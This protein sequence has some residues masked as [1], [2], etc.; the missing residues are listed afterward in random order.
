M[1]TPFHLGLSLGLIK[2]SRPGIF[3]QQ[4]SLLNF[5]KSI[6]AGAEATFEVF[7]QYTRKPDVDFP[8]A[9]DIVTISVQVAID[10]VDVF[11]T[12]KSITV[13]IGEDGDFQAGSPRTRNL[14]VTTTEGR[15]M[16]TALE[17]GIENYNDK[18]KS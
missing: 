2:C 8:F 4:Q 17:R 18:K 6:S 3:T 7:P 9:D 14:K 13:A 10:Y 11:G 5:N 1:S 15:R 12:K 16:K